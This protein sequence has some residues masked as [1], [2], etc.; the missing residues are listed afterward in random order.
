MR[1]SF[2]I[3]LTTVLAFAA[4]PALAADPVA[5]FYAGKQIDLIVGS[6]AG[7]GYDTYA[8]LVARY[9][10]RYIPGNPAVVPQNM[11]GAGSNKA[12]GYIYSM[13]PKD[14]TAIGA[15]FPG[16]ILQPLIGHIPTPHDPSKFIYVG[17]ANSDAYLCVARKDAPVHTFKDLLSQTLIIAGA[18]EGA[19]THDLP[20]VENNLLGAHFRI[21][22]GY[23]G[24]RENTMAIESGEVQGVCGYGWA[25]LESQH[26]EWLTKGFVNIIVQESVKGYSKLNDMGVPRTADFAKSEEDRQAL[27]LLYSQGVFGRPYVLPPG[28]PAERV[29]ALRKAFM[30]TLHDK[31]LLADAE[32]MKLD[33]D[34][35]SGEDLQ[36]LVGKLFALPPSISAKV[37]AAIVYKPPK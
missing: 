12:G 5:Q 29:A 35:M 25:S 2:S 21:V 23:P 36:T 15:V 4:T 11:P 33:I 8:R 37:K 6:S 24:M 9:L 18:T 10:G 27:E 28:V 20:V 19:T 16:I 13:A 34:A 7:G 31:A 17:S 22:S 30:E 32:H 1:R 3:A 26:P 14:G